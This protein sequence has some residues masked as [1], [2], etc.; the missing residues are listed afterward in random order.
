M[1]NVPELDIIIQAVSAVRADACPSA[2]SPA[3]ARAE[4]RH[5]PGAS[6]RAT[7]TPYYFFLTVF[8]CLLSGH[9]S[10]PEDH[11]GGY[12]LFACSMCNERGLQYAVCAGMPSYVRYNISILYLNLVPGRGPRPG[13][14]IGAK[15]SVSD[16]AMLGKA[17][18]R[19][20]PQRRATTRP[21]ERHKGE[22]P[23]SRCVYSSCGT[24]P[25][26]ATPQ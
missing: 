9:R 2:H 10:L 11:R 13:F 3:D 14:A 6:T 19:R 12:V 25:S 23:G 16:I 15:K 21:A 7:L 17:M 24:L 4:F 1:H 22:R 26:L 5:E 8:A 20:E 18:G